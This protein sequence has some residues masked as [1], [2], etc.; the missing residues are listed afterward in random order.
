MFGDENDFKYQMDLDSA[1]HLGIAPENTH[2]EADNSLYTS[3]NGFADIEVLA[4]MKGYPD[5]PQQHSIAVMEPVND[6][7]AQTETVQ[8]DSNGNPYVHNSIEASHV[9]SVES[10]PT[11][12][13]GRFDQDE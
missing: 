8:F 3:Q 12:I 5:E 7:I 6:F 9:A 10:F 13:I 4:S 11:D 2:V 1:N